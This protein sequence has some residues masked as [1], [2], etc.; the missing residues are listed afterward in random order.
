MIFPRL[1]EPAFLW[2]LL[3]PSACLLIGSGVSPSAA[4]AQDTLGIELNRLEDQGGACRAYLVLENKTGAAFDTLTLDLVLFDPQGTVTKRVAIE[5]APLP[6]DK[7]RVK[8][9]DIQGIGCGSIGRVL[10][11][12]VL[13]CKSGAYSGEAECAAA[14]EPRSRLDTA[15]DK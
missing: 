4:Q 5:A 7:T 13:A 6:A 11:N 8:I 12:G 1:L 14:I 3:L 15:F 9:V 10:F 2:R